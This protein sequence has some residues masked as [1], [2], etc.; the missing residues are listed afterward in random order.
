[1]TETEKA[2]G[3][4]NAAKTALCLLAVL[5][6]GGAIV[7]VISISLSRS[8]R[9]TADSMRAHLE[10]NSVG[11]MRAYAE[12]QAMFHSERVQ[13]FGVL[14]YATPY[15]R[16]YTCAD[17]SGNPVGIIDTAFA[18]A[19]GPNGAP[20]HG[21]LFLD[22]KTIG[23]KSINWVDDYALCGT[24]ARYG[25]TGCRTFIVNAD[26]TVWGKDLGESKFL[27]DFPADPAAE[28]WVIAE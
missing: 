17:G 6:V 1:M 28:G 8:R 18:G 20:K 7:A 4:S 19:Q 26:G 16:L 22:M 9:N 27:E 25:R 14:K 11:S 2:P 24:P 10:F 15:T 23:G 5:L 12:A 21:Y 13:G 3:K